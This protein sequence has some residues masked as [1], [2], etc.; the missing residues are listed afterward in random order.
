MKISILKNIIKNWSYR[1]IKNK[2]DKLKEGVADITERH[3]KN[4]DIKFF[5]E[6]NPKYFMGNDM[7]CITKLKKENLLNEV[8]SLLSLEREK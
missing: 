6:K 4:K 2:K 8:K 7:V 1:I 3:L 5:Q